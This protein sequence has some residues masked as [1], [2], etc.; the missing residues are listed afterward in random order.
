M[1]R[2]RRPC[3]LSYSYYP[4]YPSIGI[5]AV[6][7]SLPLACPRCGLGERSNFE[8][9][10]RICW[11]PEPRP[12]RKHNLLPP[13]SPIARG[14]VVR[15]F[16]SPPQS[17]VVPGRSL[18]DGHGDVNGDNSTYS[19]GVQDP[20]IREPSPPEGK[21]V[22]PPRSVVRHDVADSSNRRA[23]SLAHHPTIIPP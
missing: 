17:P 11:N 4:G 20:S 2:A 10:Q 9:G 13:S 22:V 12:S 8:G 21:R 23:G 19:S 5:R 14:G 3:F 6:V 18:G 15:Q 7:G 1:Y 16:K